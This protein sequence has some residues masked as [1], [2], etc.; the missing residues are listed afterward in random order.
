MITATVNGIQIA[1]ERSGRGS[2]LLLLHGYPVDHS[3][4]HEVAGLLGSTF[5]VVLPDL[6]GFGGSSAPGE[7]YGMAEMAADLVGLLDHL[8]LGRVSIAGHS[9]GG[10]IALAFAR[11]YPERV[12]GLGLVSSQTRADPPDR[13]EGRLATARQVAEQGV[14]FI[15]DSMAAKLSPDARVQSLCA[16]LIRQQHPAG[17][18]GALKAMAGREDTTS[19]LATVAYPVCVLHGTADDLIPVERAREVKA[20]LPAARLI[21]FPA[22]G[23]MLMMEDPQATAEALKFLA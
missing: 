2:P 4:W 10:Y 1:F 12:A 3:I 9:M 20:V 19:F 5:D 16:E 15:A 23:H 11:A 14:G 8:G 17:I 13:R 21:E 22:G 7:D 18:M 6:R